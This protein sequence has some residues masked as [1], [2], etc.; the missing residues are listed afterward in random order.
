M[1]SRLMDGSADAPADAPAASPANR[2]ADGLVE[3]LGALVVALSL[4]VLS[5]GCDGWGGE[6]RDGWNPEGD[7]PPAVSASNSGAPEEGISREL[8]AHRARTLSDL[9]YDFRLSVPAGR[10]EPV[11]GTLTL[12]F[13][14]DDPEGGPL[15]L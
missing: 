7:R 11:T 6:G 14:R 10:S 13:R 4:A 12:S 9:R 1:R 15:V 3:G 8:A 2:L 5:A